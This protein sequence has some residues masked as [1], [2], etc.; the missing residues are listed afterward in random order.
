[1]LICFLNLL[2]M[3]AVV[4]LPFGIGVSCYLHNVYKSRV[5]PTTV[6]ILLVGSGGGSSLI[7]PW[8]RIAAWIMTGSTW[9]RRLQ[10][11]HSCV[12][13]RICVST[14]GARPRSHCTSDCP[15]GWCR[16]RARSRPPRLPQQP[17]RIPAGDTPPGHL[18]CPRRR[19]TPYP[20]S[21]LRTSPPDPRSGAARLPTSPCLE[22]KRG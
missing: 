6:P 3:V 8:R 7:A 12:H 14:A 20:T 19:H 9:R 22:G 13:P 2:Q 1:M 5:M 15:G 4:F 11:G 21:P 18:A 16:C 17:A 10:N